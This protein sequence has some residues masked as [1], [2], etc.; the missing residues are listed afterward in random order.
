[1]IKKREA[2]KTASR[3]RGEWKSATGNLLKDLDANADDDDR[4]HHGQGDGKHRGNGVRGFTG[5]GSESSAQRRDNT[6]S[7]LQSVLLSQYL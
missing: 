5:H 7:S 2:G 4:A 3:V 6:R 1:M